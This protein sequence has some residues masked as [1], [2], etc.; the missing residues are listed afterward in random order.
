VGVVRARD[1][2]GLNVELR[3]PVEPGAR[4]EL[5]DRGL[6]VEP[7]TLERLVTPG[8]DTLERTRAGELLRIEGRFRASPGAL[9]RLQPDAAD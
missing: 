8:G 1:D 4:V 7:V 9:V 2:D 3:N 5:R 6:L